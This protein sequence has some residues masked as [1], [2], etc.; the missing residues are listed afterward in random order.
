MRGDQ[1]V[2]SAG[3]SNND[4]RHIFA[5]II[6][7]PDEYG[8]FVWKA[9]EKDPVGSKKSFGYPAPMFG[10]QTRVGFL[11]VRIPFIRKL[12]SAVEVRARE[13]VGHPGAA[14]PLLR[15]DGRNPFDLRRA[16]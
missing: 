14:P 10:H 7:P 11:N 2:S 1:P 8:C 12:N 5:Y 16:P 3:V 4:G 9:S 15:Q 13:I 6:V